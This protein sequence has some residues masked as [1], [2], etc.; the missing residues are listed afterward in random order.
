MNIHFIDYPGD[1]SKK[2]LEGIYVFD[3]NPQ[4]YEINIH[5]LCKYDVLNDTWA[6]NYVITDDM[7]RIAKEEDYEA[8]KTMCSELR[9]LSDKYPMENPVAVKPFYSK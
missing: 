9:K 7:E 8:F 4:T 6:F 2:R 1:M 3:Y 5:T